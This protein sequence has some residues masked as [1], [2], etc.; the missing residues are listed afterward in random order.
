MFILVTCFHVAGA[1][2]KRLSAPVLRCG[3]LVGDVDRR[4]SHCVHSEAQ[5]PGYRANSAEWDSSSSSSDSDSDS[6]SDDDDDKHSKRP[7]S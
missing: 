7:D 6:Y 2:E 4:H 1:H 3:A 5:G